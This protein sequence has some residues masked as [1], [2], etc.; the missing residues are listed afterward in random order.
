MDTESFDQ[1]PL[2]L[3]QLGDRIQ[4]LLEGDTIDLVYY[5][6]DSLVGDR[7]FL[8]RVRTRVCR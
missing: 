8:D 1:F 4:Y 3:N 7:V 5:K 2:E 6:G